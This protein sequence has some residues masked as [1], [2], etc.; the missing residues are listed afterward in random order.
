[1]YW[2]AELIGLVITLS[3]LYVPPI[4][5]GARVIKARKVNFGYAL[6]TAF[7]LWLVANAVFLI[8]LNHL[9]LVIPILLINAAV[10]AFALETTYKRGIAVSFVIIALQMLIIL[11]PFAALRGM[12]IGR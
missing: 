8:P 4:M 3:L 5:I 2:I 1:M 6:M 9:I 10:L 11:L 7:L 12:G